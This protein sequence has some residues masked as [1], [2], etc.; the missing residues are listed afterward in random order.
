MKLYARGTVL[1]GYPGTF[2]YPPPGGTDTGSDGGSVCKAMQELAYIAGYTWCFG[3]DHVLAAL[4]TDSVMLGVNW[5]D[6]MDQPDSSGLVTIT[7]G[8]Q[9][10]G[11]H[12][13]ICRGKDPGRRR[14]RCDNSWGGSWGDH[15]SFDI[16]YQDLGALLA[17]QGDAVVPVAATLPP[18]QPDPDPAD[19][20]AVYWAD[21]RLAAWSAGRHVGSNKYAAGRYAAGRERHGT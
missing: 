20:D 10:R 2:T 21:P 14:V 1:D 17:G 15:G 6:S 11:G 16:S 13:F 12:E 5:Y 9:V 18:P 7:P 4:D 8:A 19:P 3:V